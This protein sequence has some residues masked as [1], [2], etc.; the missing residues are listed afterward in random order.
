MSLPL[1]AAGSFQHKIAIYSS[2]LGKPILCAAVIVLAR[3][4]D[5]ARELRLVG[6]VGVSLRLNGD[7]AVRPVR[8][9]HGRGG[10]YLHC[11]E[12]G[13]YIQPCSAVL[14]SAGVLASECEAV[15]IIACDAPH[16]GEVEIALRRHDA[17]RR[18]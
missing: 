18:D 4:Q 15:V 16:D 6:T 14:D 12:V 7:A 2:D 10:V 3:A 8:G 1:E 5:G 17:P 9:R 11:G 13:I